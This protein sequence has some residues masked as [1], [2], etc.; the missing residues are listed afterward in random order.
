MKLPNST[1]WCY[2]KSFACHWRQKQRCYYSKHHDS[3]INIDLQFP[4]FVS[5][6]SKQHITTIMNEHKDSWFKGI[7]PPDRLSSESGEGF[8]DR[9]MGTGVSGERRGKFSHKF[10]KRD[11][12]RND[13][14]QRQNKPKAIAPIKT[15]ESEI[16]DAKWIEERRRKFPK[17]FSTGD[18][19]TSEP[20]QVSKSSNI[21]KQS[22]GTESSRLPVDRSA[23]TIAININTKDKTR[24]FQPPLPQRKKTLF[25]KLMD[26]SD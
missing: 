17:K 13:N 2:K 20:I 15:V 11:P 23:D 24:S 25:E 21:T 4:R 3:T 14:H 19:A 8:L 6:I 5:P 22:I 16:D 1:I 12:R 9:L 26:T 7:Q 10:Q 18:G